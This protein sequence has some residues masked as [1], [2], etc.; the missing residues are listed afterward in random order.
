MLSSG[1]DTATTIMSLQT[2]TLGLYNPELINILDGGGT[3]GTLPVF[4]ELLEIKEST[5]ECVSQYLKS[6]P[7][8]TR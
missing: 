6:L 3:H 7:V 8:S 5:E 2:L 4:A 1:Y